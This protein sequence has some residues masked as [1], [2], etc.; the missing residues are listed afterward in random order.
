MKSLLLVV[1]LIPALGFG[2]SRAA[3]RKTAP[4]KKAAAP[5]GR[6]SKW[7]IER[8]AIEGNKL[9]T[10]LQVIGV[11]ALKVGQLAGKEDFDAAHDRLLATGAFETVSYKFAPSKDAKGFVAT[12]QITEVEPAYPLRYE[13]LGVPDK[14]IQA[15]LRAKDPLFGPRLPATKLFLERYTR[16]VQEFLATRNIAEKIAGRVVA[17]APEQFEIV[18]RPAKNL[19]AVAEVSFEGNRVL[20]GNVLR[21]TIAGVGVGQP[22][23]EEKFRALLDTSIR[24]LYEARG[25][26]R[27]AF[28]KVWATPVKDVAGLHVHVT[29]KEGES[30]ELGAIAIVGPTPVRPDE[31]LKAANLKP[32]D[33]A[34]FDVVNE[35]LDKVKAA[36]RRVGYMQAKVTADRQIDDAKKTVGLNLHVEQGVQYHMGKL[37]LVGLD[38]H[39][40]SEINRLWTMK[41]GKPFNSDYPEHFLSRVREDGVFDGLGQ[42]RSVVKVDE[43]THIAHVTLHFGAAP[44]PV[45]KKR[46]PEP[47]SGLPL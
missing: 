44:P 23:T 20:P 13:Q 43:K 8:I 9:Y 35:G 45:E 22:Y 4:Q 37:T 15:M 40:E 21:E 7:P 29:V 17:V 30:Y 10:S 42:T 24:P 27:V 12:F 1:M 47:G 36:V 16:W 5:A 28:P 46:H 19:P 3:Q 18:F 6:A 38:L 2:Q 14:D 11:T 34:N 26:V 31:L 39:A 41:E 33:L 32:G 25:R